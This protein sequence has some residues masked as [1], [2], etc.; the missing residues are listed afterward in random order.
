MLLI[1]EVQGMLAAD[2]E[3]NSLLD[4]GERLVSGT[5]FAA[6]FH[7]VNAIGRGGM[8]ESIAAEIPT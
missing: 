7:I 1:G 2:A 5:V 4:A 8:G 6:H 3:H